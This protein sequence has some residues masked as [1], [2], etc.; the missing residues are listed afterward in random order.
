MAEIKCKDCR[1]LE[2]EQ[3]ISIRRNWC[4]LLKIPVTPDFYCADAWKKRETEDVE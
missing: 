3:L 1:W 2:E 4:K